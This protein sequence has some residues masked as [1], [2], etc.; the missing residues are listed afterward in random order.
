MIKVLGHTGH[1]TYIQD[2]RTGKEYTYG[3]VPEHVYRQV[4]KLAS[5]GAVGK[6]YI[7][8]SQYIIV[9]FDKELESRGVRI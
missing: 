8:L 3:S 7:L 4:C 9:D 1:R 6:V 5:L 2:S